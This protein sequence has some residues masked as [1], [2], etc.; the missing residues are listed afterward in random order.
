MQ[1]DR[2]RRRDVQRFL[3]TG[4]G[5]P[6]PGTCMLRQRCIDALPFMAESPRTRP[7]QALRMQQF[8]LVRTRDHQRH[9]DGHDLVRRQALD[10]IQ[11]E[12]GPHAGTQDLGR[13]QGGSATERQYLAEPDC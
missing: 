7:G 12:M 8:P 9:A 3:T 2:R 1:T 10:Q 11:A 6:A 4:L 5:N 13:P